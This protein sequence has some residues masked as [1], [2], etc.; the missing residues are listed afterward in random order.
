M[1][2][3]HLISSAGIELIN[4]RDAVLVETRVIASK[5]EELFSMG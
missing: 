3:P 4:D 1:C 5:L 2:I